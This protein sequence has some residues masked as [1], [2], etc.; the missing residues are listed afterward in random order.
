MPVDG[1]DV[2]AERANICMLGGIKTN[3]TSV[4]IH[5]TKVALD[6]PSIVE[7]NLADASCHG[8]HVVRK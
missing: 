8:A 3:T 5:S 1:L 7:W 4:G 6:H 2:D